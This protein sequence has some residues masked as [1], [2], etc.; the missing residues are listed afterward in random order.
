MKDT[1]IAEAI[2][3]PLQTLYQWK[4]KSHTDW[5]QIVYTFFSLKDVSEIQPE[6]D[7]VKKILEARIPKT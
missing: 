5:R 3:I 1:E 2:G 7:R 4:K 6:I